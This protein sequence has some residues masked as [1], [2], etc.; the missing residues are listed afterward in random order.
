[1]GVFAILFFSV[2]LVLI[3]HFLLKNLLMNGK[4]KSSLNNYLFVS[5]KNINPIRKKTK[6]FNI[7]QDLKKFVQNYEVSDNKLDTPSN[8]ESFFEIQNDDVYIIRK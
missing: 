2:I 6:K 3:I 1:M 4:L 7:Q 5:K 8:L